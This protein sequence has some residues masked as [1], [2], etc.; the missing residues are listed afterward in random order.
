MV[1]VKEDSP[2]KLTKERVDEPALA[3]EI[4]SV[5]TIMAIVV[6]TIAKS[7][8]FC[9]PKRSDKNPCIG[10]AIAWQVKKEIKSGRRGADIFKAMY[11]NAISARI[12]VNMNKQAISKFGW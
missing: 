5:P 4:I 3:V 1:G 8:D 7:S 2:S 9:L 6:I 11:T 10:E 12:S